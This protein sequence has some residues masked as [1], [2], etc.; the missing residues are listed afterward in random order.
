MFVK[1]RFL[2]AE[3]MQHLWKSQNLNIYM[4]EYR[5]K[6]SFKKTRH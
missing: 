6:N 4:F 3:K 2:N 1:E 5:K